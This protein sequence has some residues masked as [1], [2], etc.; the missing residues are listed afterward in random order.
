MQNICSFCVLLVSLVNGLTPTCNTGY[1][2]AVFGTDQNSQATP[3][4][5]GNIENASYCPSIESTCC[6]ASDFNKMV[7]T[8]HLG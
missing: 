1:Y 5:T 2:K 8:L 6:D 4:L 3:V 7:T